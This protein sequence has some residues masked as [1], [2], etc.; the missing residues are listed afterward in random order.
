MN[1]AMYNLILMKRSKKNT[2]ND[3]EMEIK[4]L[5]EKNK[6]LQDRISQLEN[7]NNVLQYQ[8]D[9]VIFAKE[10]IYKKYINSILNHM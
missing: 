3:K 8:R 5:E 10:E 1:F 7:Q 4:Q 2:T 6:Y 9:G